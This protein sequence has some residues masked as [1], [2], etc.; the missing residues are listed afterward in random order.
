MEGGGNISGA[1]E[2]GRQEI[3]DTRS[4]R[5]GRRRKRIQ[6]HRIRGGRRKAR[7]KA[8]RLKWAT[9]GL[10]EPPIRHGSLRNTDRVRAFCSF[11][12]TDARKALR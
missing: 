9:L 2:R 1:S 4:R 5:A 3:G 6:T 12:A 11:E 10:L 7:L 8:R